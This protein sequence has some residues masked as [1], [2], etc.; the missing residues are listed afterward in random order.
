MKLLI[1]MKQDFKNIFSNPSVM[2]F[3]LLYPTALVL[4]F[5]F[6]FSDMYKSNIV[7]S[8]D[9]YGVTSEAER[10]RRSEFNAGIN[11]QISSVESQ[12]LEIDKEIDAI[13]LL[14]E[15]YK[16]VLPQL[17]EALENVN[18]FSSTV[19]NIAP[20]EIYTYTA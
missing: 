5:G 1:L 8:Y 10:A 16:S 11:R 9:F 12:K 18:S 7:S 14:K 4:L 3:S 19:A 20:S 6:L 15:T 13:K 17:M 2:L